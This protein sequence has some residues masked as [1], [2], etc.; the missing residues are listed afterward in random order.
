MDLCYPQ[1]FAI[2]ALGVYYHRA[3]DDACIYIL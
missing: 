1:A 2:V 3:A